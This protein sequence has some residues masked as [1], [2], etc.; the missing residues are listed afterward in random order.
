MSKHRTF[1]DMKLKAGTSAIRKFG[2]KRQLGS[3]SG[4]FWH[5][6]KSW[7]GLLEQVGRP[8]SRVSLAGA[9]AWLSAR[10]SKKNEWPDDAQQKGTM[11]AIRRCNTCQRWRWNGVLA[12]VARISLSSRITNRDLDPGR[13]ATVAGFEPWPHWAS[14]TT[15]Q[16]DYTTTPQHLQAKLRAKL[17]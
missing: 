5:H 2:G 3:E 8:L 7:Q 13:G 9:M 16:L 10:Q 17:I 6:R 12:P 4:I 1:F 11:Y 15:S 14:D